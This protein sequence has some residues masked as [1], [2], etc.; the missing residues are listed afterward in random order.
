MEELWEP[1]CVRQYVCHKITAKDDLKLQSK[2]TYLSVL[3]GFLKC[4]RYN[5]IAGGKE[6]EGVWEHGVEENIWT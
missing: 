3:I 2:Y 1:Y 4:T 6:A 5:H